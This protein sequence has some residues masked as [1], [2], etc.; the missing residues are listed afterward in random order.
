MV[1]SVQY[2]I[3]FLKP[4]V[5]KSE[6]LYLDQGRYH[7]ALCTQCSYTVHFQEGGGG[8]LKPQPS[9]YRSET[10]LIVPG[11]TIFANSSS[12]HYLFYCLVAVTAPLQSWHIQV[13]MGC[14][15]IQ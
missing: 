8:E 6:S 12:C 4:C 11:F 3:T 10:S 7:G 13:R 5:D 2:W 15:E 9:D 14:Q 1:R